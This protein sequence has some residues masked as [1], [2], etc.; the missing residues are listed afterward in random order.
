MEVSY[1]VN[2]TKD[3]ERDYRELKPFFGP[4]KLWR[5]TADGFILLSK[6]ETLGISLKPPTAEVERDKRN[7][8]NSTDGVIT[9]NGDYLS[10]IPSDKIELLFREPDKP[11]SIKLHSGLWILI[12]PRICERSEL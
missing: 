7:L 3:Q 5:L 2:F 8:D 1:E 11:Y 12:A 9:L 10:R 6:D 4:F